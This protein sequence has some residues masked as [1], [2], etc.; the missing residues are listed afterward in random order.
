MGAYAGESLAQLADRRREVEQKITT[1]LTERVR[2]DA[3]HA[4]MNRRLHVLHEELASVLEAIETASW[5]NMAMA[6]VGIG[7]ALRWAV[8]GA[9]RTAESHRDA[10]IAWQRLA[11]DVANRAV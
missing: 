2:T 11:D 4:E 5:R 9:C 3:E 8:I 1:R 10:A 7:S 6:E